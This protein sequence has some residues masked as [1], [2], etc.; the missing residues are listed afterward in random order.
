[1]IVIGV[2]TLV[3]AVLSNMTRLNLWV[4]ALLAEMASFFFWITTGLVNMNR[5]DLGR[6]GHV[7]VTAIGMGTLR[8]NGHAAVVDHRHLGAVGHP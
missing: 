2:G 8:H 3:G 5:R 1:M 7:S 4:K 6:T